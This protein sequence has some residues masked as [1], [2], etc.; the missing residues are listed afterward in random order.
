MIL[1]GLLLIFSFV[2]RVVW[3]DLPRKGTIFDE[4][5]YVNAARVILGYDVPEGGKYGDREKF[6]DPNK[7]HPPLGKLL[8]AGSMAAFGDNGIGWRIP[9]VIAGM[10]ALMALFFA[11][12]AAGGS[13]WLALLAV[14]LASLDNLTLVHGRIG[15]LDMMA[16]APALVASWLAL[17]R[18][19][20]LAALF[21]ALG[22]AREAHGALR[23][24]RDPAAVAAPGRARLVARPADQRPR[25][26]SGRS[27]S[28]S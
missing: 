27:C 23:G 8:I 26:S 25:D 22:P 2:V 19:W 3:L 12:R 1:L 10:V 7:E 4:A 16:L 18:R 5:Y 13:A 6:L 21:M 15:V 20:L 14:F 11:I 28:P 17:R 24:R 9:S